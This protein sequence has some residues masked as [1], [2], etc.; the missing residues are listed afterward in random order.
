MLSLF[1]IS[2]VAL[3]QMVGIIL[4]IALITIPVAIAQEFSVDF[5]KMMFLSAL[6]GML[7]CWTGLIVSYFLEIPSGATIIVGGTLGL[8][9]TKGWKRCYGR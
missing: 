8:F 4:V 5:K 2:I 3:I 7:F 6:L 9:F 1:A